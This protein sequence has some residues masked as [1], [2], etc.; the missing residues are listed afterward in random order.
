MNNKVKN[1]EYMVFSYLELRKT[2]GV[3]GILLPFILCLGALIFFKTGIQDSVSSYYHTDMRDVFVGMLFVI[4][5][6]LFS[7][8][9]YE[10]TD[11]LAGDLGC[12]FAVGVALFPT[13]P[14]GE[15]GPSLTGYIH[16]AFSMLFFLTLIYFSLFLFTK[17]DPNTAPTQRKRQR[18]N[19]YKACGITMSAC[20]LVIGVYILLPDK[21]ATLIKPYKPV[22]WL[23]ALSI[24]AFGISWL[25]KGETLLKDKT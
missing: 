20:I 11:D 1:K 9:G 24:L 12:V 2:I 13:T 4:G 23:E 3:L 5:F 25:I 16:L 6:F 10:R 21:L 7:Y 18:N 22:Y 17:T 8:K 14:E 15:S 19:V